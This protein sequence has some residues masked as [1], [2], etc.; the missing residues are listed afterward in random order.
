[1]SRACCP[2]AR[3]PRSS[4]VSATSNSAGSKSSGSH[5]SCASIHSAFSGSMFSGQCRQQVAVTPD[6]T[7]ILGR[8]GAAPRQARGCGVTLRPGPDRLQLDGVPPAVTEVV[9]VEEPIALLG[10]GL[11]ESDRP[12]GGA[13]QALGLVVGRQERLCHPILHF[14]PHHE[15]VQMRV[16]P[17]HRHLQDVVQLRQ[18]Q[19]AGQPKTPPDRRLRPVQVDPHDER[20]TIRTPRQQH[21]T[22]AGNRPVEAVGPLER[23]PSAASASVGPPVAAIRSLAQARMTSRS[24]RAS[25]AA[26]ASSG[27]CGTQVVIR[28]AAGRETGSR[29]RRNSWTLLKLSRH[30]LLLP[31]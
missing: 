6:A 12:L 29:C 9:L 13:L 5:S 21:R 4:L 3:S 15:V 7:D 20:R 26:A 17:P 27:V 2:A 22:L 18:F 30:W 31:T 28:A 16:G 24:S 11:V 14:R 8:A 10:D 19:V 23:S 25:I 1:M